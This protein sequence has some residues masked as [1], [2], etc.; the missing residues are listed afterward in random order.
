MATDTLTVS[1][2]LDQI[3]SLAKD[4]GAGERYD[5]A[6]S[7]LETIKAAVGGQKK[8][9]VKDP[10]APKR[11]VKPDS[12]INLVN[13]IVW[14]HLQTLSEAE[15]D[16]DK[17]TRIRSAEGRTQISVLVWAPLK[18]LPSAE[19]IAAMEDVTLDTVREACETW[20]SNPPPAKEKKAKAQKISVAKI[21]AESSDDSSAASDGTKTSKSSKS[22][23]ANMSED[24]KAAFYKARGAAAAAARASNKATKAESSETASEPKAVPAPV[25]S[26]TN[27]PKPI[28]APEP[29]FGDEQRAW[30]DPSDGTVYIRQNNLLWDSK[31]GSWVGEYDPKTKSI[32][33]DA[34]EPEY[35]E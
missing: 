15:T 14:P 34:T 5:L 2:P 30:T 3:L 8:R 18:D 13:K 11:E 12:Y 17:K 28:A 27:K 22:K 35:D 16:P 33:R 19:R 24:E 25:K 21:K 7:L 20:M 26:K 9:K 23:L 1:N 32:N 6:M 4:L 10:N 31:D 29:E